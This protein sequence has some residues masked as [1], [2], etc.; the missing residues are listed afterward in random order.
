MSSP[1]DRVTFTHGPAMKNRFM[2]SPL[3]N[4]Q[5]NPDGTL[6]ADEERWLT[7]RA[8]GGFGMTVTCASHV[9]PRGQGFPG[10]LGCFS[11]VHLPGLTRLA[12]GIR[13]EGSVA[14]VQLHHAGRRAPAELIGTFPAAPADDPGTGARQLTTAEAHE[15]IESF[16]AAAARCDAAGFNGVEL[17][18]AHDYLLCEF[19]NGELNDRTDDYGGSREARF[20]IFDEI[21]AGIRQRCGPDFHVGVRLSPERFGLATADVV[22]AFERLVATQMVDLI[23]LSLWDVFKAAADEQFAS[24]PLLAVFTGLDRGPVR[25]AV[26]GHLYSGSDVQRAID[27]GADIAA[28]G[29]AAITNHDF[30]R[31]V[32]ADP[33]AA[34]RQLPVAREVLAAEG[35]GPAFLEYMSNWKGF[36]GG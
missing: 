15:V 32:Q 6:T 3:T 26:A 16:V 9:D 24:E 30:P 23:D 20:R 4:L 31:L 17:H 10:Q 7:M 19:L 11:D 21:I 8:A 13:A 12:A 18:G 5:S 22:D 25:L 27:G 33:T 35:L 29:R 1:F 36:V 34:M 14:I 28:I 2:L